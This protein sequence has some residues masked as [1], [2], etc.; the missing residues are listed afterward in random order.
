MQII[1]V[2]IDTCLAAAVEG[3]KK[4]MQEWAKSDLRQNTQALPRAGAQMQIL[5]Y[6][7]YFLCI[8]GVLAVLFFFT[9]TLRKLS[10]HSLYQ[11][12]WCICKRHKLI[13]VP[14]FSKL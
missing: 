11:E 13:M 1:S 5:F 7:S 2:F 9:R 3:M 4:L 10:C 14:G 6:T 12:I 8:L